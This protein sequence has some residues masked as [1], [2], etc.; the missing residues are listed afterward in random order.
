MET[1]LLQQVWRQ[2]IRVL[3]DFVG[4]SW[5]EAYARGKS[6]FSDTIKVR[7]LIDILYGVVVHFVDLVPLSFLVG[8]VSDWRNYLA[9]NV[10][11]LS[12]LFVFEDI[13]IKSEFF[14][15]A[16]ISGGGSGGIRIL[17]LGNCV[18]LIADNGAFVLGFRYRIF[19]SFVL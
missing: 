5:L 7:D 19:V 1:K 13:W 9:S 18:L 14:G 16:L 11:V 10:I 4:V 12:S 8:D 3:V 17:N 6:E 15:V 2:K